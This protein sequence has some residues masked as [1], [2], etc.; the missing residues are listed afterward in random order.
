MVSTQNSC[1][2]IPEDLHEV[3]RVC[4]AMD[5]HGRMYQIADISQLCNGEP[6]WNKTPIITYPNYYYKDQ[7]VKDQATSAGFCIDKSETRA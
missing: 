7:F 6:V 1:Q 4:L 3:I 2:T 5:Q